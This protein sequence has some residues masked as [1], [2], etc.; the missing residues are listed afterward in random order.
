MAANIEKRYLTTTGEGLNRQCKNAQN[1]ADA[2]SLLNRVAYLGLATVSSLT[3]IMLNISR[4]GVR[5]S[6]KGLSEAMQLSHK[7]LPLKQ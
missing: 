6:V 3:E 1:A 4:A 5:N 2:Y 7:H